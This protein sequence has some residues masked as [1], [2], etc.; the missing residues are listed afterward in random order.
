[1]YCIINLHFIQN[2]SVNHDDKINYRSNRVHENILDKFVGNS[3]IIRSYNKI[4]Y[5][6]VKA[7]DRKC[8]YS[9]MKKI[10]LQCENVS[11]KIYSNFNQF[12]LINL[13]LQ[14]FPI[15]FIFWHTLHFQNRSIVNQYPI[16]NKINEIIFIQAFLELKSCFGEIKLLKKRLDIVK[17]GRN[18][19]TRHL[20]FLF[21]SE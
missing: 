8:L 12:M 21:G 6:S 15:L 5:V 17:I 11:N 7:K 18:R 19:Q 13:N 16:W 4:N 20:Q 2:V 9:A 14:I 1:M 10:F 3:K